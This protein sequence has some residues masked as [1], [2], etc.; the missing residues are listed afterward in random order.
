MVHPEMPKPLALLLFGSVPAGASWLES[1]VSP[2]SR[3]T[4]T[5]SGAG[6]LPFLWLPAER[7]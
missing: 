7:N 3:D 4:S 2:P 6:E 1:Q 5:V